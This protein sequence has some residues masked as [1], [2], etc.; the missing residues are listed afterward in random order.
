MAPPNGGVF[1]LMLKVGLTGGIGSGK[2][3]VARIFAALGIPVYY[4]D[5]AAKRIQQDNPEVRKQIVG[6][7]GEEA[8]QNGILNRTYVS[9]IVFADKTK[10][11]QLNAIVHPAT[12]RD[13]E[14]WLSAQTTAYAIKEAALIFESGS[15]G[16]LDFIIGVTAPMS[17][18]IKRTMTRDGVTEEQVRH[19]MD[20]QISDQIK[21]RLCD[22]VIVNDEKQLLIPQ[23]LELHQKLLSLSQDNTPPHVH[24]Q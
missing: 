10:L 8:Y 20:K 3:M 9:S 23:V 18:R 19:R 22:A 17:L 13:A 7:L 12:I 14:N 16:D 21:M 4:A 1:V 2:T 24:T 15:Q 11:E 6:L 5:E